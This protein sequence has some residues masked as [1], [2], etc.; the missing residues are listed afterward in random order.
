MQIGR[1]DRR[2]LPSQN[3]PNWKKQNQND[4]DMRERRCRNRAAGNRITNP[5]DA[6]WR[7]RLGR[8]RPFGRIRAREC[9]FQA[10]KERA[11][12]ARPSHSKVESVE[13]L[14]GRIFTR[15]HSVRDYTLL[16][17]AAGRSCERGSNG[18][19]TEKSGGASE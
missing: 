17:D 9:S 13:R 18:P 10:A 5:C 8:V 6:H 7:I 4:G 2:T 16:L 14:Q 1:G 19:R 12:W 15:G 3:F 11:V